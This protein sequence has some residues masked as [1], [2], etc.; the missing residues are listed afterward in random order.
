ME[1]SKYFNTLYFFLLIF[2]LINF[3]RKAIPWILCFIVIV[4]LSD[5]I[6]SHLLK[7]MVS[8]PRP[9]HDPLLLDKIRLL[10]HNCSDNPSFTSSHA[11]NHF[12]MAVFIFLTLQPYLKKWSY[13]FFFWAATIGYGQ[14][15]IGVH[16]PTDVI[17]GALLGTCIGYFFAFQFNKRLPLNDNAA[18]L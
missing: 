3:G 9:C 7:P 13:L 6:S 15:Y 5:Q 18:L 11:S 2:I 10:L 12:A 8:R 4:T 1:R 16:Y 14:V 17:G